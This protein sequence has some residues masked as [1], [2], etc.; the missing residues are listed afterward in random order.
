[1]SQS[2]KKGKAAL[3]DDDS[4]SSASISDDADAET[5]KLSALDKDSSE[6]AASKKPKA[7]PSTTTSAEEKT[8]NE[9]G[10]NDSFDVVLPPLLGTANGGE[11]T[12]MIEVNPDDAALLDYE[13]MSGAIGRFEANSHGGTFGVDKKRRI[14][15]ATFSRS[16]N[17]TRI[18]SVIVD[19]KGNRYQGS[20]VPGPTAL[21]VALSK[22]GQLRVEGMT[23]E[24][25]TLA[26]TKDVMASLDAV[27]HGEFDDGFKVQ[28]ENVNRTKSAAAKEKLEAQK[29]AAASNG[30]SDGKRVAPAAAKPARKKRR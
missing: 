4:I 26:K 8:P 3:G 15:L 24:F 6:K 25:A 12:V 10:E 30:K 19:L 16:S 1:M 20:I 27:V 17:T 11:C 21:V 5:I 29:V 14:Y 23:D 13:G 28:D 18:N 2:A 22:G 7:R 9:D